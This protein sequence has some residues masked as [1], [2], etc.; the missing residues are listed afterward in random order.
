MGL[1]STTSE[2]DKILPFN[3]K[4]SIVRGKFVKLDVSIQNILVKHN[5]PEVVSLILAEILAVCCCFASTLKFDGVFTIQLN[6]K[7]PIKTLLSD[8]SSEGYIRGYANYSEKALLSVNKKDTDNILN[9]LPEGHVAF[10][11]MMSNNNKRYQGIVPIQEGRFSNSVKY[12][13]ENS[14]QTNTEIIS[15]SNL[16][17][18]QWVS[19]AL[20]IQKTPN[21]IQK[22]EYID[23]E[24]KNV[25]EDAKVFLRSVTKNELLSKEILMDTMLFKLFHSLEV[26]VQQKKI[27]TDFCR[28]NI[29]R[30]KNTLINISEDEMQNLTYDDG[31]L[32][33]KCEF[34][35]RNSTFSQLDLINLRK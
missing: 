2:F 19:S 23:N 24:E 26:R 10:T 17:E 34:C 31:S 33:I 3:L 28:C 7:G 12:Y 32:D 11:A 30:V 6:S 29:D 1:K 22:I 35:K 18:G 15:F 8:I 25:Y 21:S 14:E 27:V 9:L 16:L 20:M 13:F 4:K 5:Y